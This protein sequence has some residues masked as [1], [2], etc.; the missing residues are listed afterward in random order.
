MQSNSSYS[1]AD[2]VMN[3]SREDDRSL[4]QSPL[5]LLSDLEERNRPDQDDFIKVMGHAH[6]GIIPLPTTEDSYEQP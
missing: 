4:S 5:N 1:P 2:Q 6:L 3:S